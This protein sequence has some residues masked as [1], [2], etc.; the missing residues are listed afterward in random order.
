MQGGGFYE[1]KSSRAGA[2][3][4]KEV[5]PITLFCFALEIRVL[6]KLIFGM[7]T[8]ISLG[9]WNKKWQALTSFGVLA[10]W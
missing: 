4:V 1:P 10:P 5:D 6:G 7:I 8:R 2:P 9:G 3:V